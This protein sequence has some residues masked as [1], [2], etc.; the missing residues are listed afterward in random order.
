MGEFSHLTEIYEGIPITIDF[1]IISDSLQLSTGRYSKPTSKLHDYLSPWLHIFFRQTSP[2]QLRIT[3]PQE[4]LMSKLTRKLGLISRGQVGE[5]DLIH[6]I[7]LTVA[8]A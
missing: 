3:P 8:Q 5:L 4:D 1:L 7:S 6:D 2:F